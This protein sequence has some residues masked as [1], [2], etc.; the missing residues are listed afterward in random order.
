MIWN[1]GWTIEEI[2]K[3]YEPWTDIWA[4]PLNLPNS[5]IAIGRF[6][7]NGNKERL[8]IKQNIKVFKQKRENPE[9]LNSR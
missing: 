1:Q 4:R 9:E 2:S 3:D 6:G 7:A 8:G 5:E